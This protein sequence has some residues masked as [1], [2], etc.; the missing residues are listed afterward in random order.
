M[1]PAFTL[2]RT[3]CATLVL[4]MALAIL[5]AC[6]SLA[7]GEGPASADRAERLLRQNNPTAAAQMY[8]RLAA[9]NTPPSSVDF[10]LSA[11]RAW[12]TAGKPADAR[13]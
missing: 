5:A 9:D 6:T 1:Q 7:P 8:E 4:G 13:G 10:L 12:L 2:R 11:A 3:S